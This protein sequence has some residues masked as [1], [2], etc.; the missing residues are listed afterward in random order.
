MLHSTKKSLQ[1]M[2]TSA[3]V[4]QIG[5]SRSRAQSSPFDRIGDKNVA[6]G[7]PKTVM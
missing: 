1:M 3:L 7:D 2:E 4:F 6:S 5:G